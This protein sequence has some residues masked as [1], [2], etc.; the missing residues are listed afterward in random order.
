MVGVFVVHPSLKMPA[1]TPT[2]TQRPDHPR[3]LFPFLFITIAC[4][5]IS[6]FHALVSSGTT[7]KMVIKD[8]TRRMIGYGAMLV[9]SVVSIVALIA[10]LF[11]PPGRLFRHQPQPRQV[12]RPR[13]PAGEHHAYRPRSGKR[14]RTA[15]RGGVARPWLRPDLFKASRACG[16]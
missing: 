4:G 9:E 10:G 1:F 16:A 11:A 14:G 8:P 5:A 3:Q 15:G 2:S 13:R 7:P 12:R 6:G